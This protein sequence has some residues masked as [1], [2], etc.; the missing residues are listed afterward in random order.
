MYSCGAAQCGGCRV[1]A[2]RKGASGLWDWG[3]FSWMHLSPSDGWNQGGRYLFLVFVFY[4]VLIGVCRWCCWP[5]GD[6]YGRTW[7]WSDSADLRPTRWGYSESRV[8]GLATELGEPA[9]FARR[10]PNFVP[11]TKP[12]LLG[13]QI[14]RDGP[15][16]VTDWEQTNCRCYVELARKTDQSSGIVHVRSILAGLDRTLRTMSLPGPTR[17]NQEDT[18]QA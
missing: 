7:Q 13:P 2:L 11:S 15:G 4:R 9:V 17:E 5:D 8:G 1:A 12:P 6:Y 10:S 16:S 14:S 3:L 18:T